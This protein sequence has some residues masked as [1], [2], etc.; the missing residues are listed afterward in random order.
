MRK[1]SIF[2]AG[3]FAREVLALLADAGKIQNVAAFFES[4][5]VWCA[6]TVAG[7]D[8][9]PASRF[10]PIESDMVI[11]IGNPSARRAVRDSLP[12]ETVF[13]I[14]LHPSVVCSSTVQLSPGTI[15][16]A[17]GILTC[18]IV[19]GQHVH[20]NLMTTVGHDCRIDDFVTTAPDVSISGNCH[21]GPYAYLGTKAC[22]REGLTIAAGTTVG[23]GAVVVASIT[24]AGV[25]V[26][27]PA[28]LKMAK[29]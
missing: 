23:M 26:G 19:M 10:D 1:I 27:N 22:L 28:R 8:V 3:G 4:D 14:L 15:I 16:C 21:V 6:R 7:L 2:G 11:A 5:D 25:Y 18:D 17:G 20:L 9:L 13:P 12:A 24:T 29:N